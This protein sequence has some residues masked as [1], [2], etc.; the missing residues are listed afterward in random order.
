MLISLYDITN[1]NMITYKN[2]NDK[3]DAEISDLSGD[4]LLQPHV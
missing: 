2:E 4:S 1:D 3:W